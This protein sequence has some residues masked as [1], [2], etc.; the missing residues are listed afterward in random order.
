M[1]ASKAKASTPSFL[2]AACAR[3]FA[4]ST[5]TPLVGKKFFKFGWPQSW[6]EL[7]LDEAA[8][9]KEPQEVRLKRIEP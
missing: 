1:V 3:V 7:P 9:H 4:A 6:K 8:C 5:G 2:M